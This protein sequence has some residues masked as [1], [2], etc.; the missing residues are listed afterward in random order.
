MIARLYA[1]TVDNL[2]ADPRRL[3]GVALARVV[4]GAA[5]L[6]VY[7]A[8]YAQRAFLWG[9]HG[10]T[11]LDERGAWGVLAQSG[12]LLPSF[13][14]YFLS[15]SEAWFEAV[16]HAGIVA[17]AAFML[18]GG[19]VLALVHWIFLTSLLERPAF[20]LE[21]GD[22]LARIVLLLLV[23]VCSN[24]YLSPGA[25]RRRERMAATGAS[26]SVL[27]HNT[28]VFLMVV[29]VAAVYLA[30]GLAKLE[31]GRWLDGTAV[32]YS[33]RFD[34]MH[35]LP[36]LDWVTASPVVAAL[37]TRGVLGLELLYAA[38]ILWRPTRYVAVGLA[39][40]MH[41]GIGA[42]MGLVSFA[43]VMLA[44]NAMMLSDDDYSVLGRRL[45]RSKTPAT[46]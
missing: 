16:Y 22:K 11:P 30:A 23:A 3:I 7:V 35:W 38:L 10:V 2:S 14:L 27:I 20:P 43:L 28:A 13:S 15:T 31:S 45:F 5:A 37:L 25:R 39:V 26:P 19:R 42:A 4:L 32:Y 41:L 24:A 33:L 6:H 17:A 44:V 9:P 18:F 34:A 40:L 46:A 21:G 1:A 29:Q 36:G 12:G 8:S